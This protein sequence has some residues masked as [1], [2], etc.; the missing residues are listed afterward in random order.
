[1]LLQF[2]MYTNEQKNQR[3]DITILAINVQ[4]L[5]GTY[6]RLTTQ[7]NSKIYCSEKN[8]FRNQYKERKMVLEK[9][10]YKGFV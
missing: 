10:A 7:A 3:F 4:T 9:R 8:R 5:K 2:G 6:N 1:M